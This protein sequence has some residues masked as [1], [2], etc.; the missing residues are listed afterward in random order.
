MLLAQKSSNT[1]TEPKRELLAAEAASNSLFFTS[2]SCVGRGEV[3]FSR[4]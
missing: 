4:D 2:W 1:S 3:G